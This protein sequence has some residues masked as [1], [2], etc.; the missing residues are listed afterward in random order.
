MLSLGRDA[1]AVPAACAARLERFDQPPGPG[2]CE[3]G[4][5]ERLR[6]VAGIRRG[7]HIRRCRRP[8]TG[9]KRVKMVEECVD[10]AIQR[11]RN[12]WLIRA[13]CHRGR[14]H[15]WTGPIGGNGYQI[16]DVKRR[17]SRLRV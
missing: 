16:G 4:F 7:S 11:G 14:G 1:P 9:W 2:T 6:D 3:Q 17:N 13:S 12:L 15:S 5:D 8:E 10:M